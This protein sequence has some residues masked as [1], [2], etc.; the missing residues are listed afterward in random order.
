MG[1]AYKQNIY[2]GLKIEFINNKKFFQGIVIKV[3]DNC[4]A[5]NVPVHQENYSALKLDDNA[6]YLVAYKD[7]AF[8]CQSK[9]LGCSLG[10]EFSL[11]IIDNPNILNSIERRRYPRIKTVMDVG[12]YFI[13]DNLEYKKIEEV[14]KAYFSKQKKTF[15]IDLSSNGIRIVTYGDSTV[16]K[17]ALISIS[18]KEKIDILCSIVRSDYDE[19][20]KNYKTAMHFEDLDNNKWQHINE[21]VYSKL[22]E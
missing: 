13:N 15:S 20:N 6:D 16:P 4:F 10:D 11:L 5:V 7:R 2:K 3:Y 17:Y 21:F 19:L 12:Y 9:I 22:K 14:P 18:I 1:E 8:K